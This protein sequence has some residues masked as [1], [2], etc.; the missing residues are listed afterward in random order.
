MSFL[1]CDFLINNLYKSDKDEKEELQKKTLCA[2]RAII[3][4]Y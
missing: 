2:L 4:N 1:H 3:I